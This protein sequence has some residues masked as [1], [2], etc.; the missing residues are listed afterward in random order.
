MTLFNGVKAVGTRTLGRSKKIDSRQLLPL[1]KQ[2][3]T[4]WEAP[5]VNPQ[6]R[7]FFTM[8]AVLQRLECRV[9][10]ALNNMAVTMMERH[11]YE[12]AFLTF[13]DAVVAIKLAASSSLQEKDDS[14]KQQQ[15]H[16]KEITSH[17]RLVLESLKRA[18]QRTSC[19]EVCR[20]QPSRQR[21]QHPIALTV[22]TISHHDS[23]PL[24]DEDF[25]VP[26][27]PSYYLIRLD[28]VD[29]LDREYDDENGNANDV[30]DHHYEDATLAKMATLFNF[31][32]CSLCVAQS[33]TANTVADQSLSQPY[34]IG[35]RRRL[36]KCHNMIMAEYD[37]ACTTKSTGNSRSS[38]LD[39]A[40]N[41]V[42]LLRLF[43]LLNMVLKVL[44]Q[45]LHA[46][47]K[48]KDAQTCFMSLSRL[49][50]VVSVV[51]EQ[52]NA[53]VYM[54]LIGLYASAPAA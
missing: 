40:R 32:I 44:G 14:E 35:G 28:D 25:V 27:F 31:G 24:T 2:R 54:T 8:T 18:H 45:T 17:Q 48:L 47:G 34:Y 16:P 15:Q 30:V 33:M 53:G 52:A 21:L 36:I 42:Y 9:A 4:N 10:L 29:L 6:I 49:E 11:C 1:A 22:V 39:H 41:V 12:Q 13:Q 19:P 26:T 51:R 43:F 50:S 5:P 23:C 20:R 3:S 37:A 38:S 7:R 46:C